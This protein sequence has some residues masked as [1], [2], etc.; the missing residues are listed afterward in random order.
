MFLSGLVYVGYGMASV[1]NVATGIE[2][3]GDSIRHSEEKNGIPLFI[4]HN[5]V[6]GKIEC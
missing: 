6:S 4:L 3:G 1:Q 5:H 2:K